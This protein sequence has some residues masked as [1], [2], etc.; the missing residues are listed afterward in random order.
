MLHVEN[1]RPKRKFRYERGRT[2]SPNERYR[3]GARFRCFRR[4]SQYLCF[5]PF[6]GQSDRIIIDYDWIRFHE[7]CTNYLLNN[8]DSRFSKET[9]V[10]ERMEKWTKG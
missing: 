1:E 7:H 2:D 4:R 10:E 6:F 5:V 9:K 3:T 8:I